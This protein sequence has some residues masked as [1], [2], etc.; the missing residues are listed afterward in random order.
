M[1]LLHADRSQPS[2]MKVSIVV[3][4]ENSSDADRRLVNELMPLMR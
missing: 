3:D 2:K 4:M 1:V